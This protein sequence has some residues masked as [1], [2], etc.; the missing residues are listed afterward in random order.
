MP[1]RVKS[2]RSCYGC[3]ACRNACSLGCIEMV[4]DQEGFRYPVIDATKCKDCGDC[5]RVCPR[6]R[7]VREIV[8]ARAEPDVY[9]A[10]A[11]DAEIRRQSSSGGVFSIL[12][13]YILDNH[14]AVTGAISDGIDVRHI[15]L[16]NAVELPALRGSTAVAVIVTTSPPSPI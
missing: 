13:Q 9:A 3:E 14:G 11:L 7:D 10:Y 1:M 5:A 6:L 2:D 8:P 15:V 16:L 4:E 12:A